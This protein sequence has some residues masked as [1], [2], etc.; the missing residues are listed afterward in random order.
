MVAV[1]LLRAAD[2]LRLVYLPL[3]AQ[4]AAIPDAL[5]AVLFAVTAAVELMVL[6][7]LSRLS[8]R[9]GSGA[10]LIGVCVFGSASFLAVTLGSGSVVLIGSQV[11]YAVFAAGFQSI[12]MVRLGEIVPSGAAGGAALFTAVVQVGSTAGIVAPL[13]VP[14]FSTELFWFG[15]GFC[16]FAA[17]LLVPRPARG[18]NPP[19]PVRAPVS[20]PPPPR[21][22]SSDRVNAARR[23]NPVRGLGQRRLPHR[24]LPQYRASRSRARVAAGGRHR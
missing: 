8:D 23:H 6:A 1:L 5:I 19:T 15:A 24:P 17:L 14:G 11:L 9:F 10:A 13:A 3:Y 18:V 16:A 4:T 7:P 2:S 20:C 22:I 12:G 21:G